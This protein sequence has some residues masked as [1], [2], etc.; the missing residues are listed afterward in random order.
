MFFI[1][2]LCIKQK[3]EDKMKKKV[4]I[5]AICGILGMQAVRAQQT[6]SLDECID[7]ALSNNVS[8]LRSENSLLQSDVDI[9]M[10]KEAMFPSL[11]FGFDQSLNTS[12]YAGTSNSN[13][14]GLNLNWTLFNGG[15]RL[16]TL[17]L[18][19]VTK[20]REQMSVQ[21][22]KNDLMLSVAEIYLQ[23]L[24]SI[25]ARNVNES[26]LKQSE[27]QLERAKV[28]YESG[29]IS[30]AELA[31]FEAQYSSDKYNLTMS[32]NNC[33]NYKLM[34]RQAIE[35][36]ADADFEVE[37]PV[38]ND[39][40]VAAV[41]PS[42]SEIFARAAEIMPEIKGSELDIDIADRNVS[43]AKS[44]YYPTV[45]LSSNLGTAYESLAKGSFASQYKEQFGA[46]ATVNLS[47]PLYSNGEIRGNVKKMK[48]N[49][50]DAELSYKDQLKELYKTIESD[51]LNWNTY[52]SQYAAAKEKLN[53]ARTSYELVSEKFNV[54]IVDVIE[55]LTEKNNM[56]QAEQEVLQSKYMAVLNLF[57]LKFYMGERLTL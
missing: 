45:S 52:S 35:Y 20:E 4:C 40:H 32:E 38:L 26:V 3:R 14:V 16:K 56:L 7:L 31:Q 27:A 17:E 28:M 47:I 24:Y 21:E 39:S 55:L 37:T 10:A 44:S 46:G 41:L 22:Q 23:L 8:I 51:Y 19:K 43:I 1:C 54:G 57:Y 33:R 25:E 12:K 2:F 48:I 49:Q 50:T 6:L 15:K 9:S 53:S 5:L 29:S 30:N 42:V 18:N 13:N 11:S 34:L 36:P